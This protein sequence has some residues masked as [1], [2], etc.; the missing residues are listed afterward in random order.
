MSESPIPAY[1]DIRKAFLQEDKIA[2]TVALEKLPRFL[3][4]LSSESG[5]V[6]VNLKFLVNESNQRIIQGSLSAH[7]ELTCQRCLEPLAI[8]LEDDIS[9]AVLAEAEAEGNL[10]PKLEPWVCSEH[11]L[12][13]AELVEEQLML[14][15]PIV[16]YHDDQSCLEKLDYQRA[17][18][19][20][21]E[22]RLKSIATS[23]FQ[24]LKVLKK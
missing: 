21:E 8:Q 17:G 12:V 18:M 5:S 20:I 3:K 4:G 15:M 24:A 1:V 10:D 14:C 7:V 11:K 13:L 16:S 2:G 19:E 6:S 9:L 22:E 23:P